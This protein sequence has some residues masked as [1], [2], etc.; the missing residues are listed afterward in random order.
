MHL[1]F[2]WIV[3]STVF[4]KSKDFNCMF[5]ESMLIIMIIVFRQISGYLPHICHIWPRTY[6][7]TYWSGFVLLN[8]Q[9]NNINIYS[10]GGD[11]YCWKIT[12]CVVH[13]NCLAILFTLIK[14]KMTG[15]I[16]LNAYTSITLGITCFSNKSSN[17]SY[18]NYLIISWIISKNV[19]CERFCSCP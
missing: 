1:P 10:T 18:S 12:F 2:I 9:I 6:M 4:V 8:K 19:R 11:T 15:L 3:S 17:C 14:H 5:L 7:T 16:F 13:S